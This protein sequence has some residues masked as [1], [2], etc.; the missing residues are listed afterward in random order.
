MLYKKADEKCPDFKELNENDKIHIL[1]T[2]LVSPTSKFVQDAFIKRRN[3]LY[4]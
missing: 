1:M 3:T 4:V 2:Q